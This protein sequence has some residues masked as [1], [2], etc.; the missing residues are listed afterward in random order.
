MRDN[1]GQI[2]I[3]AILILGM[4][5]VLLLSVSLPNAFRAERYAMDVQFVSDAKYATE[6][7]AAA[8]NG[9]AN[10]YEKKKIS[11]YI[12]GFSSTATHNKKHDIHRGTRI[13]SPDGSNLVTSVL[14]VRRDSSGTILQQDAYNFTTALNGVGW[15]ITSTTGDIILEDLGR[16]RDFEISWKSINATT[17]DH[18]ENVAGPIIVTCAMDAAA[19]IAAGF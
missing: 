1:R 10:T 12:P 8:A 5:I 9:I 4:F 14:I 3:E 15:T 7:I 11:V 17:S 13:C 6:Q 2:T 19:I 16:W 18:M